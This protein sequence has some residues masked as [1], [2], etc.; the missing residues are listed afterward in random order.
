MVQMSRAALLLVDDEKFS[1]ITMLRL[2]KNIGDPVTHSA[3]NGLE[4]MDVLESRH[5]T[6]H[7]V[8][9]DFNMPIMHG[10]QL[11]K[12]IRTGERGIRRNMPVIMLT[13]HGEPPLVHLALA[14]DVNG[15]V[16]K[17]AKKDSMEER[18]HRIFDDIQ[19]EPDW[20]KPVDE[21]IR[22]DV[23]SSI[24][25]ILKF[26][27]LSD[28]KSNKPIIKHEKPVACTLE[29]VR[30]NDILARPL[31]TQN[32]NILMNAGQRLRGDVIKRLKDLSEL[33]IE[34]GTIWIRERP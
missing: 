20:L 12:A 17:P 2:L 3:S 31:M 7:C 10:L 19:D 11:L 18:L 34:I 6:I 30:E 13:A 8:I 9:A 21:Y 16:L 22:I 15:F 5:S 27:Q 29:T 28:I 23:N 14:L 33:N 32:G 1:Q 26:K 24:A 25:D 4:A